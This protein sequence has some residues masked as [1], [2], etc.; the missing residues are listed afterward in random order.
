MCRRWSPLRVRGLSA[1]VRGIINRGS[2]TAAGA[3]YPGPFRYDSPEKAKLAAAFLDKDCAGA[4]GLSEVDK[5]F[6]KWL[7]AQ[8]RTT[9]AKALTLS[10][11]SS[12][13]KLYFCCRVIC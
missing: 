5:A 3:F 7:A 4:R 10:S 13:I 1:S 6:L 9:S 11:T 12:A 8:A 2:I